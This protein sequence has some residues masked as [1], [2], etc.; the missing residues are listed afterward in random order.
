MKQSLTALAL[1]PMIV[2][3]GSPWVKVWEGDVSVLDDTIHVVELVDSSSRNH[4]GTTAR[5]VARISA[6]STKVHFYYIETDT[7]DC[8]QWTYTSQ[9]GSAD[10]S[11]IK[12]VKLPEE[13]ALF[14]FACGE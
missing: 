1:I 7:F 9:G 5:L 3:A 14:Q 12:P 13:I 2:L 10:P 8:A 11:P 4:T 6:A